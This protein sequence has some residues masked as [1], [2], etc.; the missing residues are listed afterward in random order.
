MCVP[1]EAPLGRPGGVPRGGS[2]AAEPALL[3]SWTPGSASVLRAR[4]GTGCAG[5]APL[6]M[7]AGRAKEDPRERGRFPL[8]GSERVNSG[9]GGPDRPRQADWSG[10]W[11]DDSFLLPGKMGKLRHEWASGRPLRVAVST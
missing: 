4:P 1:R 11:G 10:P 7:G 6:G 2:G 9:Y 3:L 5:A 8:R